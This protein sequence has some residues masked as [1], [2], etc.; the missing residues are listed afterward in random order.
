MDSD[1]SD[2]FLNE[3]FSSSSSFSSE[4]DDE[5]QEEINPEEHEEKMI[6]IRNQFYESIPSEPIEPTERLLHNLYLSVQYLILYFKYDGSVDPIN[7]RLD[8]PDDIYEK[9]YFDYTRSAFHGVFQPAIKE[10][11][12]D[13]YN[14]VFDK[15]EEY[16]KGQKHVLVYWMEQMEF[17]KEMHTRRLKTNPGVGRTKQDVISDT[18]NA[19]TG[20]MYDSE[21]PDHKSWKI[22]ILNPLPSD[23]DYRVLDPAEG[24]PEYRTMIDI[25]KLKN[26]YPV[27]DAFSIVVTP[28]WE[29]IFRI[30][31]SALHFVDYFHAYTVG[32]I[33][34][35]EWETVEP[36]YW[37]DTWKT[38]VG[39]EFANVPIEK[40]SREK[41]KVPMLVSRM[42]ELRDFLKEM[43]LF[44]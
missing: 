15:L 2:S 28:E 21:N 31:H 32:C 22:L 25:Q 7:V 38:L 14:L 39:E 33:T 5:E 10:M 19:V 43:I 12:D 1:E 18:Y 30:V 17:F 20:E 27:P 36:M 11:G 34:D 13:V 16:L 26:Q 35:E 42:A 6:A 41:K 4:N 8:S 9:L 37:K 3:L 29:K 44:K 24:G 23:F 40:F